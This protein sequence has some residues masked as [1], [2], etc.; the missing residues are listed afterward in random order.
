LLALIQWYTLD[1]IT[2]DVKT[3]TIDTSQPTPAS[4]TVDSTSSPTE[5]RI[6]P[7]TATVSNPIPTSTSQTTNR[8]NSS[9]Q[10]LLNIPLWSANNVSQRPE[11]INPTDIN[12]MVILDFLIL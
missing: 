12:N 8:S 2:E 9:G 5:A 11:T 7:A 10:T 6:P 3:I 1:I 4:S